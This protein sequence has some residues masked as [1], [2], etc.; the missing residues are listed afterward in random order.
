MWRHR[1]RRWRISTGEAEEALLDRLTDRRKIS[2]DVGAAEGSYTAR[3]VPLSKAVIAFEPLPQWIEALRQTFRDT[4]I[5][6]IEPVALTDV[7]GEVSL[8]V[9]GSLFRSTID[10]ENSLRGCAD[11]G[12]VNVPARTLDQYDFRGVGF[13]KIDVEGHEI[14]VLRGASKTL[15]RERPKILIEVEEQ[16]HPGSIGEVFRLLQ[17]HRYRGQFLLNGTLQPIESF[18]A[19]VHQ[20]V[21]NLSASGERVGTYINNFIFT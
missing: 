16:H 3:L 21:R 5:V 6:R 17:T 13:L 14:A 12:A 7:R 9:P 10:P 18:D 4:H 19:N 11:V 15:A 8:R 2:I 20:N 1:V